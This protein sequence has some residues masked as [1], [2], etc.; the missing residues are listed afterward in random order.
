IQAHRHCMGLAQ[1]GWNYCAKH[2]VVCGV[3]CMRAS[4]NIPTTASSC[5]IDTSF[6]SLP[7][8]LVPC[9]AVSVALHFLAHKQ[10]CS[11][12]KLF[13]NSDKQ[14]L[15]DEDTLMYI[16]LHFAPTFPHYMANR[17]TW[18]TFGRLAKEMIEDKESTGLTTLF[19]EGSWKIVNDFVS[20]F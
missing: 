9:M 13:Y 7:I 17:D 8:L 19:E 20:N 4:T 15:V 16:V 11:G 18:C 14:S 1:C 12:R 2:C 10:H 5:L 6:N 3:V